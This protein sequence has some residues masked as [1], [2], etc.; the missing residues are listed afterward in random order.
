MS[1]G[2]PVIATSFPFALELA[3]AYPDY[4]HVENEL[5]MWP[6]VATGLGKRRLE[7]ARVPSWSDLLGAVEVAARIARNGKWRSK[8]LDIRLLL[9]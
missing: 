4:I 9:D 8:G 3:A 5:A 2:T 6:I 7:P 1:A